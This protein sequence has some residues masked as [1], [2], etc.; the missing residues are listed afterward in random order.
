[1]GGRGLALA[2]LAGALAGRAGAQERAGSADLLVTVAP[3]EARVEARFT[4]APVPAPVELRLL[5]R[6]CLDLEGFHLER[7]GAATPVVSQRE[8][9][10]LVLRDTSAA[11]GDTL[12]LFVQYRVRWRGARAAIP[13]AHLASPIPQRDGEREGAV[14]VVARFTDGAG[15]VRFPHMSAGADAT[16]SA[17]YVAVPS[18]VE[19]EAGDDAGQAP[20]GCEAQAGAGADGGLRWRFL[21]L[22]GIM[23]AWVPLYLAWA[24]RSGEGGA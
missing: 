23:V 9:P 11:A 18:F 13:L 6:P 22:V 17:R 15:R 20:D 12:R 10:W 19:V 2:A 16:W 3:G 8:D 4:V 14:R 21:T 5:A 24:R 7:D 1:M